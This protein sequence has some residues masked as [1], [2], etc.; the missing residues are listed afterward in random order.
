[1]KINTKI[2][3][4]FALVFF[5]SCLVPVTVFAEEYI[6]G[7][8]YYKN[9]PGTGNNWVKLNSITEYDKNENENHRKES[10]GF[11]AW[12]EYDENENTLH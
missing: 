12:T 3:F 2:F 7:K 6:L 5:L 4:L 10:D 9:F 1:M 8:K 11:E